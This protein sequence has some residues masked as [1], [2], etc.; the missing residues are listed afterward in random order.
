VWSPS[1]SGE[2]SASTTYSPYFSSGHKCF[3]DVIE[4]IQDFGRKIGNIAECTFDSRSESEFNATYLYGQLRE[5]YPKWAPRLADK[6]YFDSAK[7]NPRIQAV[8]LWT[9]EA[10][11]LLDHTV[12]PKKRRRRSWETLD[13]TGRFVP[14]GFSE[15]WFRDF[16]ADFP[17]VL[18]RLG[19]SREELLKWLREKRLDPNFAN[20]IRFLKP[21][22]ERQSRGLK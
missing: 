14:Y 1:V 20:T 17:N 4:F 12:G 21:L 3:L 2:A 19:F 13:K 16:S 9:R 6:I 10:M 11:K 7:E 5:N 18:E 22:M 15:D 8:D